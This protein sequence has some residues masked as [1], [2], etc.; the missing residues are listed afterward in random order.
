MGAG[1]IEER[2]ELGRKRMGRIVFFCDYS[3]ESVDC[4]TEK[5]VK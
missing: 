5:K 2:L 3:E 1:W 4:S